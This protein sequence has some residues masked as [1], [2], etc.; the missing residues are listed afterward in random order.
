MG[1]QVFGRV[2][3]WM[4]AVARLPLDG[5]MWL[6]I[7]RMFMTFVGIRFRKSCIL[8]SWMG[9]HWIVRWRNH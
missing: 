6:G 2:Y 8:W 1:W 4:C 7:G 3:G 5:R 9:V